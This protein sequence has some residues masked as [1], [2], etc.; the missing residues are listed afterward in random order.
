MIIILY[1]GIAFISLIFILFIVNE[2]N[3]SQL[4]KK[5][6]KQ[7]QLTKSF[8]NNVQLLNTHRTRRRSKK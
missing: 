3:K 7:Q 6:F 4:D 8:N 5:L 2:I 1:I